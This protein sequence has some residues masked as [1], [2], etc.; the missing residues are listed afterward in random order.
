MP[1]LSC[2]KFNVMW[3]NILIPFSFSCV[4]KVPMETNQQVNSVLFLSSK[5]SEFESHIHQYRMS[6]YIIFLK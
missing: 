6:H 2:L 5:S 3:K 1:I 4:D